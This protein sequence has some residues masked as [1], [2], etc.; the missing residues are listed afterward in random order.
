MENTAATYS[1]GDR[2]RSQRTISIIGDVSLAASDAVDAAGLAG[3]RASWVA[4]FLFVAGVYAGSIAA[5]R[6][7]VPTLT[8]RQ[9]LL[10]P[11]LPSLCAAFAFRLRQH[12]K[13]RAGNRERKIK[14][15]QEA[16][17]SL[18][19]EAANGVNA[20]RANL[21][22]FLQ[23][24]GDPAPSEHLR[25]VEDATRRIESAVRSSRDPVAWHMRRR[26]KKEESQAVAAVA[27]RAAASAPCQPPPDY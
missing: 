23:V 24:Q 12:W 21:M 16:L 7:V 10:V 22:A 17:D 2:E 19:H 14:I 6:F 3:T 18:G 25:Q 11:L 20:V 1:P 27:Q 26:K 8:P 9:Y 4:L 13:L 5:A 15:W